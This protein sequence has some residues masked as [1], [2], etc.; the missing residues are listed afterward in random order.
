[1]SE[2]NSNKHSF[3]WIK[4]LN[5]E[6]KIGSR[7]FLY[8]VY[9][10]GYAK[11]KQQLTRYTVLTWYPSES[12]KIYANTS[13]VKNLHYWI[14]ADTG[15]SRKM[16]GCKNDKE[17]LVLFTGLF[18]GFQKVK[19]D[20]EDVDWSPGEKEHY[21]GS[22]QQSICSLSSFHLYFKSLCWQVS[23]LFL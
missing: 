8:F 18:L 6:N 13:R 19:N 16:A 12:K 2:E 7:H 11:L 15:H 10:M 23:R 21:A 20:V 17:N 22:N 5:F 3:N 4:L 9:S 14:G 1:M